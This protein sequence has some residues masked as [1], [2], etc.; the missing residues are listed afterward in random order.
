MLE[1]IN[2]LADEIV[3]PIKKAEENL[4]KNCHLGYGFYTSPWW[5]KPAWKRLSKDKS[6]ILSKVSGLLPKS[7]SYFHICQLKETLL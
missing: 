7:Q 3:N 1:H 6:I 2:E 4:A 5:R